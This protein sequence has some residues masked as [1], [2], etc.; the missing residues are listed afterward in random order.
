LECAPYDKPTDAER[1]RDLSIAD[2]VR[3]IAHRGAAVLILDRDAEEAEV[4]HLA[5]QV[6]GKRV[7]AVD[8]FRARRDFVR[9]E[10]LHRRAQE[11]DR[12]AVIERQAGNSSTLTSLLCIR[13][14]AHHHQRLLH[15][16][17]QRPLAALF[18]VDFAAGDRERA[19]RLH[20]EALRRR[21]ARPSRA[22]R[23]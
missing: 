20:H 3:E 2:A 1:A 17:D 4:A 8:R 21:C 18:R 14:A 11:V 22:R 16:G 9:R 19:A 5:P 7:G 10:L 6:G 23:D 12:F 15:D 13:L